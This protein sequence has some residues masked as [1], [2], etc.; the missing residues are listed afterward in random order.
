MSNLDQNDLDKLLDEAKKLP[1][2][3]LEYAV[4]SFEATE[5]GR[6]VV[7]SN[8]DRRL[9]AVLRPTHEEYLQR[10]RALL[11]LADDETSSFWQ[12]CLDV[13]LPSM[14]LAK[15]IYKHYQDGQISQTA[16]EDLIKRLF[17]DVPWNAIN[18]YLF[19]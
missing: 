5:P 6:L 2:D 12:R 19:K 8:P 7:Q 18:E 4:L 17:K 3:S 14:K 11:E 9:Y 16:T 13:I 1:P 15:V 10:L